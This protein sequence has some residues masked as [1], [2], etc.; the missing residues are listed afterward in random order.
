MGITARQAALAAGLLAAA[1]AAPSLR[2]G[3][4]ADD[5]WVIVERPF[6]KHPP[7][8]GAVLRE[9]YWPAGFGGVMWRPVVLASYALDYQLGGNPRWFH[10]MNVLWAGVAAALLALLACRLADPATGLAAGLLFAVHPVHVEAVANVVGRTELMAAAGYA[11]ALLCALRA[12]QRPVYLV[13][14]ALAATFA[15]SCKEHAATLPAAVVLVYLG[16]RAGWRAAVRPA[17]VAALPIVGYFV[18]RALIGQ[19]MLSAGGLAPGLGG[20]GVAARAWA[21]LPLS[22][23]WWRLLLFPAHLSAD[24]SPGDVVVSTGLT[25]RHVLGMLAWAGAGWA[26]WRW[27]SAVPGVAIGLAWM[28]VTVSPVANILVPTELLLAERTLYLPS[29]GIAFALGAA[30]TALRWPARW[31]ITLLAAVVALGAARSVAR[32]SVWHDDETH[33]QALTRNAPRSYRTLWLVGKD[34]FQAG[35]WG[36]G[37]RLLRTAI[38]VAPQIAGPRLDLARFYG[39]AGLWKPAVDQLR[40]ATAVD[41]ALVPAWV[42]LPRAL[43]AGGDTTAAVDAAR[44]ALRRF[45]DNRDVAD[46]AAAV[47]AAARRR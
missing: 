39:G 4:V 2:N 23:E 16:S 40:A 32:V 31:R 21:M 36:T 1:V 37:E 24:Y 45:P 44:E 11:A 38:A 35:R 8:V 30:G 47:L 13:G 26:A 5:R 3:F 29:W 10:A 12:Q 18:V 9:P 7:S 22:L 41:S 27:R 43:L 28:I 14:V 25:A 20:L 19:P 33:F 17:A 34:E 6:L 42:L 46:S 15:I